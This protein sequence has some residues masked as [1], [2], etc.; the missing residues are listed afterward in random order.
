L[1]F[2]FNVLDVFFG[3]CLRQ[4]GYIH[5][6]EHAVIRCVLTGQVSHRGETPIL[7]GGVERRLDIGGGNTAPY[8]GLAACG[9]FLSRLRNPAATGVIAL[10]RYTTRLLTAML[11]LRTARL[12]CAL[13]C[14]TLLHAAALG[15]SETAGGICLRGSP[16]KPKRVAGTPIILYLQAPKEKVWGILI[17]LS[18]AGVVLRGLDLVVFDDWMR[19]EAHGEEASLGLA[20][21][22]YPMSRVVRMERDDAC[23]ATALRAT[24]P[25]KM[26]PGIS[27]TVT[28]A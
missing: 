2:R 23:S 13:E 18:P 24:R 19:Q 12:V 25:L 9:I 3:R 10:L 26:R 14:V 16:C 11:C 28:C 21:I 7:F 22:F 15:E 8:F 17:S 20:T 5:V 1:K 27:G 4:Y 6:G